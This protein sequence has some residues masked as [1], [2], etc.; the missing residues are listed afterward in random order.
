MKFTTLGI[1]DEALHKMLDTIASDKMLGK[2]KAALTRSFILE[3]YMPLIVNTSF[4]LQVAYQSYDIPITELNFHM[5]SRIIYESLLKGL[6]ILI[7]SFLQITVNTPEGTS[8]KKYV[9]QFVCDFLENHDQYADQLAQ[10][11]AIAGKAKDKLIG[12]L[13]GNKFTTLYPQLA[14][15]VKAHDPHILSKALEAMQKAIPEICRGFPEQEK[16]LLA[17]AYHWQEVI[18]QKSDSKQFEMKIKETTGYDSMEAIKRTICG[19]ESYATVAARIGVTRTGGTRE[20]D[21][22]S[23]KPHITTT[24]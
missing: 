8:L 7:A 2:N 21:V 3:T 20:T 24:K 18:E 1:W 4:D 13:Y 17:H 9:E 10:L 12:E 14:S 23:Q 5:R 19:R 6:P 11:A 15:G 16:I 22:L